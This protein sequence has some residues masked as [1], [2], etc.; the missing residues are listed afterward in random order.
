M[1]STRLDLDFIGLHLATVHARELRLV[2]YPAFMWIT[3]S[4]LFSILPRFAAFR[5]VTSL[6]LHSLSLHE[7]GDVDTQHVF[8]H[9]SPTVRELD[10]SEP[11]ATPRGLIRFLH[12]FWTLDD[13]S[14]S[15]PEWDHE[16]EAP[17]IAEAG[18]LPPL[19][20][21]LHFLRLHADSADFVSLLA[22]LPV[23][24]QHVSLVNCQL[25][26]TPINRLL[27]RLSTSLKSFSVSAW[28]YGVLN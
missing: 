23:A 10:L 14:I 22:G 11:R 12:S 21:T 17:P 7:F 5:S 8:G 2:Q 26:S 13:L 9:F 27:M 4:I 19:H 1:N 25:P 15:D 28:F 16:T 18:T 6:S 3:P 20:G 24:F